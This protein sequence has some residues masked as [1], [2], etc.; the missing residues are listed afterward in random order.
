[1]ADEDEGADEPQ[2][3]L[4]VEDDDDVRFTVGV[5][6]IGAGFTVLEATTVAEAE[7]HLAQRDVGVALIDLKL[8][9]EDGWQLVR[10]LG[11]RPHTAVLI[12]TGEL[13]PIDAVRGIEL[14]ADDYI[15]K[16]FRSREL[17]ARVKRRAE[18]VRRL[19]AAT[20]PHGS[21]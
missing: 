20:A 14:G 11:A 10:A 18:T 9:G 2:T 4:V 12:V 8:G 3:V 7:A 19:R 17:V 16:P 6:L 1:M 13:D 5:M 21:P 15:T